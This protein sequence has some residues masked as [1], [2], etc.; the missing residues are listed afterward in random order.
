[1]HSRSG[2]SIHTAVLVVPTPGCSTK[3]SISSF[4]LNENPE[5][6]QGDAYVGSLNLQET[7]S[8]YGLNYKNRG[9]K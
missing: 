4:V 3:I 7:F 2:A 5:N 8:S 6:D 1:M 9:K